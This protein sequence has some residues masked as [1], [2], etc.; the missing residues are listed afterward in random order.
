MFNASR[1]LAMGLEIGLSVTEALFLCPG[2]IMSLWWWQLKMTGKISEKP[3][4][5]AVI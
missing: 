1:F 4:E 2:E 5:K 3:K